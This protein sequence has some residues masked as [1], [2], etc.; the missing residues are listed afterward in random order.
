MSSP[1]RSPA[2]R[3]M[4]RSAAVNSAGVAQEYYTQFNAPMDA[5]VAQALEQ[6]YRGFMSRR[7]LDA[8]SDTEGS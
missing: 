2:A 7:G 8:A 1:A 4:R 6:S 3:I 5:Q